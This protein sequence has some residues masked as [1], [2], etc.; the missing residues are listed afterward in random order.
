VSVDRSQVSVVQVHPD[1]ASLE[2]DIE[3]VADR[4]RQAYAQT[5]EV[6]TAVRVFGM[7]TDNIVRRLRQQAGSEVP[8]SIY[9]LHLGGFTGARER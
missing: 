6:S 9:P 7:P 4:A 8:L 5:L 2:A 1:A 3:V